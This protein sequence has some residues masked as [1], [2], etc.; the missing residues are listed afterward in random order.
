MYDSRRFSFKREEEDDENVKKN[1]YYYS[2][3]S[4]IWNKEIRRKKMNN[5]MK[6][7][8]HNSP[9][10]IHCKVLNYFVIPIFII[11]YLNYLIFNIAI[12]TNNENN[13]NHENKLP[14][15]I[16]NL[17]TLLANN[18]STGA[19][20]NETKLNKL[21]KD[22][23][24]KDV[25]S[26]YDK[27]KMRIL[28]YRN[29]FFNDIFDNIENFDKF[30]SFGIDEVIRV[31]YYPTNDEQLD[32]KCSLNDDK[33]FS[34]KFIRQ[35]KDLNNNN[36]RNENDRSLR[37]KRDLTTNNNN[38]SSNRVEIYG[39]NDDFNSTKNDQTMS[40]SQIE[41]RSKRV[42]RSSENNNNN[43]NHKNHNYEA[44]P[45]QLIKS[46]STSPAM[47]NETHMKLS[48]SYPDDVDDGE[49]DENLFDDKF[50]KPI[51]DNNFKNRKA[52]K[53]ALMT[54]QHPQQSDIP[55]PISDTYSYP[56]SPL[57]STTTDSNS[58]D[59]LTTIKPFE[60]G[61]F[62]QYSGK[63][64]S[65]DNLMENLDHVENNS[66]NNSEFN[67]QTEVPMQGQK[68]IRTYQTPNNNDGPSSSNYNSTYP[69][70]I[71]DDNEITNQQIELVNQLANRPRRD[72]D[73]RRNKFQILNKSANLM[74]SNQQTNLIPPP[75]QN[76]TKRDLFEIDNNNNDNND[77]NDSQYNQVNNSTLLQDNGQVVV[78]QVGDT[79][80]LN[81]QPISSSINQFTKT[82]QQRKTRLP[83]TS[84]SFDETQLKDLFKHY[85]DNIHE[86]QHSKT[87]TNNHHSSR[88][89][90]NRFISGSSNNQQPLSIR[91]VANHSNPPYLAIN[92]N[93]IYTNWNK[94]MVNS[95][96]EN[97]N[98]INNNNYD[99]N[100][101]ASQQTNQHQPII[102]Q[103]I[104]PESS[105]HIEN[106]FYNT[107]TNMNNN[108]LKQHNKRA[109]FDKYS[110]PPTST[111]GSM[112]KL[113]ASAS[114]P[115][116]AYS[117]NSIPYYYQKP[118]KIINNHLDETQYTNT[119]ASLG[120]PGQ[121]HIIGFIKAAAPISS[122][123]SQH[124][125]Q[126]PIRNRS[127]PYQL[128]AS[129][130]QQQPL[131]GE[132]KF[133]NVNTPGVLFSHQQQQPYNLLSTIQPYSSTQSTRYTKP[134]YNHTPQKA[135]QHRISRIGQIANSGGSQ[136]AD[137]PNAQSSIT[138][139][140]A[141]S[142]PMWSDTQNQE[143]EYQQAPQTI[144]ITAVPNGGFVGNGLV[145][146]G[147][148]GW[149]GWN[150]VGPWNG[151]QVL[152]VNRQPQVGA[153]W[154][155]WILPVAAVLSLP[156]ILGALFVPVF[157]KSVMFL[158]QI[159]Q[160]LGLLMPPASLANHL[161]SS[162]HSSSSVG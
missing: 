37:K 157:L 3:L 21:N 30:L 143:D 144:Q 5:K 66:D 114:I 71:E 121:N 100:R 28:D 104:I 154:R 132:V 76:P 161:A 119:I 159:L 31:V 149:N 7:K 110:P 99:V 8:L 130:N 81:E 59:D 105:S 15:Q 93:T 14:H 92:P 160:M 39:L 69:L 64:S 23:W 98:D 155:Q 63:H 24:K 131:I 12:C 151:R 40:P 33:N 83:I 16:I 134:I 32:A 49:G 60:S 85:N 26:L 17:S 6:S 35:H 22:A 140:A 45:Y 77:S 78:P 109:S 57:S 137:E 68:L 51:V 10:K 9:T 97:N 70:E 145:G 136:F 116:L 122:S 34:N 125:S 120:S 55:S 147:W 135:P 146:N 107:N 19:S 11:L 96:N 50:H 90:P 152:L 139:S 123:L 95:N 2:L 133:P 129:N 103:R 47:I 113:R 94:Y 84:N 124:S 20:R 72:D 80:V 89:P 141:T 91:N 43:N 1:Y 118:S 25:H 126:V 65:G 27:D 74:A 52:R 88:R 153:E 142:E 102:R 115:N 127:P 67:Q 162:S 53:S 44:A 48:Q 86:A 36:N 42:H 138:S 82:N 54:T 101:F 79:Q 128:I 46:I 61:S 112:T 18:K 148:N 73:K 41:E 29:S 117:S 108:V 87:R 38:N 75:E 111:S 4:T 56:T 13:V 150:G 156:L 158:I 58:G 62:D 106:S